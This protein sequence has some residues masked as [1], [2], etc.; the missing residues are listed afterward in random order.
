MDGLLDGK[1]H[2]LSAP[3]HPLPLSLLPP[4]PAASISANAA[5]LSTIV[6]QSNKRL[7]H[8]L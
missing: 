8:G 5:C 7:L 3:F 1:V 4:P 6:S 2:Q